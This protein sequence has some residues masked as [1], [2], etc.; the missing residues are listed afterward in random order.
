M[1]RHG[2]GNG[3]LVP[4]GATVVL[5]ALLLR[6]WWRRRDV[7]RK[8]PPSLQMGLPVIGPIIQLLKDPTEIM[9]LGYKTMGGILQALQFQSFKHTPCFAPKSDNP[10]ATVGLKIVKVPSMMEVPECT[11]AAGDEPLAH[12]EDKKGGHLV[13]DKVD[14]DLLREVWEAEEKLMEA[15]RAAGRACQGAVRTLSRTSTSV[16]EWPEAGRN[17]GRGG[18]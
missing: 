8:E 4:A 1:L 3:A 2:K 18:G 11:D 5:S 7:R 12:A 10:A 13:Q 15:G 17:S 6:R 9:R 14:F 16:G